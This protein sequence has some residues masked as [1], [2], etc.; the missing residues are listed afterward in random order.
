MSRV[1]VIV[2]YRQSSRTIPIQPGMTFEQFKL[3]VS[4]EFGIVV[5][6][7]S[8]S[9]SHSVIDSLDVIRNNDNLRVKGFSSWWLCMPIRNSVRISRGSRLSGATTAPA[10]LYRMVILGEG[11]VGKTALLMRYINGKFP[12]SW[13]P[14]IDGEVEKQA[15]IDDK[16]CR[17]QILD[18]AG[19][20]EFQN[21]FPGWVR[22]QDGYIL[23]YSVENRKSFEQILDIEAQVRAVLDSDVRPPIVVVANKIDLDERQHKVPIFEGKSLAQSLNASFVECSARNNQNIETIFQ[24]LV[25]DIRKH[26]A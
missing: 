8:D 6:R 18:T 10:M 5:Q 3:L 24:T 14:T 2:T 22:N 11:G 4:D 21:L 19:Q 1:S 16:V 12:D 25:R 26:R 13:D 20:E 17:L 23:V 7:I 9:K 15:R